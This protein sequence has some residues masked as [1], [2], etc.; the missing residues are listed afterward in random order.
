MGWIVKVSVDPLVE[1]DTRTAVPIAT[2]KLPSAPARPVGVP[3]GDMETVT[4]VL[5]HLASFPQARLMRARTEPLSRRAPLPDLV[6][7]PDEGEKVKIVVPD[8]AETILPRFAASGI[9]GVTVCA[10]AAPANPRNNAAKGSL[11][12]EAIRSY[13]TSA[14]GSV[15]H[16]SH[17]SAAAR[18]PGS[19]V[20]EDGWPMA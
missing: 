11:M 12:D 18:V 8:A 10:Q 16:Q 9:V 6:T 19:A 20:I 4:L 3:A 13:N 5:L 1:P 14:F 2:V 17:H 7:A 15:R